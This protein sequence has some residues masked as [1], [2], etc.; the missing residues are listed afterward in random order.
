MKQKKKMERSV[1]GGRLH[2]RPFSRLFFFLPI[3]P[4]SPFMRLQRR[5]KRRLAAGVLFSSS[6]P[7]VALLLAVRALVSRSLNN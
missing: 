1:G 3:S 5:L 2:L 7:R 4:R 6:A